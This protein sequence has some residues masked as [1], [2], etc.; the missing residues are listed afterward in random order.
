MDWVDGAVVDTPDRLTASVCRHCSSRRAGLQVWWM[1]SA[2]TAC[3]STWMRSASA[4]WVAR[5]DGFGSRGRSSACDTGRGSKTKTR[6]LPIDRC[7]RT[8]DLLAAQAPPQRYTGLVHSDYRLGNVM[9]DAARH[10]LSAVLDWELC[11]L[12][13]VLIDVGGLLGQLGRAERSL[14]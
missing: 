12:G 9:L 1:C 3:A 2:D 14:A 4:I 11:A 13:D 7:D 5:R 10:A 6:E 8:R